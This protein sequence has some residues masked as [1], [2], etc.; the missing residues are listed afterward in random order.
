MRT[1]TTRPAAAEETAAAINIPPEGQGKQ[2]EASAAA[3]TV[4]TQQEKP[5]HT[6]DDTGEDINTAAVVTDAV[7]NLITD[8]DEDECSNFI[9]G[10]AAVGVI[11]S[12][13]G[14]K[15]NKDS[16]G[17]MMGICIYMTGYA[18]LLLRILPFWLIAGGAGGLAGCIFSSG[19]TLLLWLSLAALGV[20][21]LS[22]LIRYLIPQR[23]MR[24]IQKISWVFMFAGPYIMLSSGADKT[25]LLCMAVSVLWFLLFCIAWMFKTSR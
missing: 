17:V 2:A 22:L 14:Y 5:Q 4:E 18:V 8:D 24:I 15:Y 13:I 7:D 16:S 25:G 23:I 1:E 10:L 11:L 6:I 21:L 19:T 3:D 9:L 20:G 12:I